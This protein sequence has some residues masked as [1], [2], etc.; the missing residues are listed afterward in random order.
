M[1]DYTEPRFN[2]YV[3]MPTALY[4]DEYARHLKSAFDSDVYLVG[5][6]LQ[7]KEWN[8]LDVRVIFSDE[9][10]KDMGFGDPEKRFKNKKWIS[11]CLAYSC[12]GK[13]MTGYI[14]DFQIMQ[15]SYEAIHCKGKKQLIG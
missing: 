4:L 14:V 7:T 6:S 15:E 13:S 5:S 8:D 12:L 10:F 11:L 3:G 2:G 1:N 9:K